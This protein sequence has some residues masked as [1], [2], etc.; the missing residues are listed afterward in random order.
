MIDSNLSASETRSK[1]N[2]AVAKK[3]FDVAEDQGKAMVQLIADAKAVGDFARGAVSPT[4]G[5]GETGT[6]FD[7][8]G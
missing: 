8:T 6:Q 1:I 3:S 2:F 5:P 7:V 4:P